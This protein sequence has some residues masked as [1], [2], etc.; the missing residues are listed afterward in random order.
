MKDHAMLQREPA[1]VIEQ[2]REMRGDQAQ[3]QLEVPQ[4]PT[5]PG[6]CDL[7]SV[8]EL[9]G[10]AKIVDDRGAQQQVTVQ[11][12]VERAELQR[13]RRDGDSVLEQ[14]A[15]VSVMAGGRA[16]RPARQSR[17]EAGRART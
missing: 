14:A 2:T 1:V 11:A 3:A 4:Q 15:E 17:S 10:L 5:L 16:P 7:S 8:A 13:H 9:R 12:R 6:A